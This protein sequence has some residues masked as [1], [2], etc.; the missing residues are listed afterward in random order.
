MKMK[1]NDRA[2]VITNKRRNKGY[3]SRIIEIDEYC[4]LRLKYR[5]HPK[6]KDLWFREDELKKEVN[7]KIKN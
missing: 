7:E 2:K 1:I 6:H 4:P 5:L 3:A